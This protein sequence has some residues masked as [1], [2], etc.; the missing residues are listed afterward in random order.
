MISTLV[1]LD[2]RAELPQT[3]IHSF[4]LLLGG[5]EVLTPDLDEVYQSMLVSCDSSN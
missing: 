2:V 4:G 3:W 1:D 5:V